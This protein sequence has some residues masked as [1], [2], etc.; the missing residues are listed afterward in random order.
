M[1]SSPAWAAPKSSLK[2]TVLSPAPQPEPASRQAQDPNPI[3]STLQDK[4]NPV[5][6]TAPEMTRSSVAFAPVWP[7]TCASTQPSF[8]SSSYSLPSA[9]EQVHYYISPC[10]S[11]CLQN[12]CPSLGGT[13]LPA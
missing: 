13:A 4:K 7:T 12:R 1:P 5:V 8:V 3:T 6:S 2:K 10:G 11:S 9:G